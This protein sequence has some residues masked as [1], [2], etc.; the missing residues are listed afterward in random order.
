M[1]GVAGQQFQINN[2]VELP[3]SGSITYTP[4][5]TAT[6]VLY[7][8][9]RAG[10]GAQIDSRQI[11]V[12]VSGSLAAPTATIDQSSLV[13]YS[14]NPTI[15]GTATNASVVRMSLGLNGSSLSNSSPALAATAQVIN[16][17]WF[18][19]IAPPALSQQSL[20]NGVYMLT[21]YDANN[22]PLATGTLTVS[23]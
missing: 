18:V 4:Q 11:T 19:L 15:T 16:G 3:A 1:Y 13:S 5:T 17:R 12:P 6:Y 2:G 8:S 23:H 21:L 22:Y 20:Q 9:P 10:E 14:P 7:C